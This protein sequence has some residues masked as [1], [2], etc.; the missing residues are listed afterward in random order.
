MVVFGAGLE[1][2]VPREVYGLDVVEQRLDEGWSYWYAIHNHTLQRNGDLLA[3]GVPVPSTSD[4]GLNR[5]LAERF[6][7]DSVRV[8]NGFY[9]FRA[10]IDELGRF[11]AR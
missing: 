8:T 1:M 7:L 10:S 2:F 6:G 4:I 11:R 9:T 5:S 3:L